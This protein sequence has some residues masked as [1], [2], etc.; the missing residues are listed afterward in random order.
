VIECGKQTTKAKEF[1]VL[2]LDDFL[3]IV[4]R[5]KIVIERKK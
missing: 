4:D 3:S 2:G 5:D 1:I